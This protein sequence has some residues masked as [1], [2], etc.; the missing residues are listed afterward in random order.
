LLKLLKFSILAKHRHTI[1]LQRWV[2]SSKDKKMQDIGV[3]FFLSRR[4]NTW[5]FAIFLQYKQG[6]DL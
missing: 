1:T 5:R 2:Y 4:G 3:T 6:V